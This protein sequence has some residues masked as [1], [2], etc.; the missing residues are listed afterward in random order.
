MTDQL[1]LVFDGTTASRFESFHR[2]NPHVYRTLVSLAR[3][4][5]NRTGQR[6]IGIKS[7]YEVARWQLQLESSDGEFN[8]NNSYTA[9][10]A[11]LIMAQERDL[12][13][14]FELRH[15]LADEWVGHYLSAVAS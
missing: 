15:S 3:E 14:I 7:L 1:L 10:F 4:Y 8:L 6:R 9:Y 2:S 5:I 13:D 11:R 12:A